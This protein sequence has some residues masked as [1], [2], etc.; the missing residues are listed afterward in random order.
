MLRSLASLRLYLLILL[1]NL[2]Q[3]CYCSSVVSASPSLLWRLFVLWC[4]WWKSALAPPTRA[5]KCWTRN[6][7]LSFT[8]SWF[9]FAAACQGSPA[10][11]A[12]AA[13]FG[14]ILPLSY[15]S[16]SRHT[17]RKAQSRVLLASSNY[18]LPADAKIKCIQNSTVAS[19]FK[20]LCLLP[21][22]LQWCAND[23]RYLQKRS[24]PS[25]WLYYRPHVEIKVLRS[26][27][28]RL[29]CP[30]V[31]VCR[32]QLLSNRLNKPPTYK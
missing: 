19:Y 27:V 28:R 32:T 14:R 12:H 15:P 5:M 26:K 18:F 10:Q 6:S 29:G 2:A 30:L 31:V 3:Q 1:S 16:V 7:S 11:Q 13:Y 21:V 24:T 9:I 22:R 23:F 25:E 4:R 8:V 17:A 20:S